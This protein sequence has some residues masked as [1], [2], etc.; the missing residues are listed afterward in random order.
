MPGL[1][2]LSLIVDLVAGIAPE[3]VG[4]LERTSGYGRQDGR[5]HDEDTVEELGFIFH[6]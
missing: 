6:A 4:A 1:V 3:L 2:G 5:S